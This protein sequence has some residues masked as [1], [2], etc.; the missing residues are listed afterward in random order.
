M[1]RQ[2]FFKQVSYDP[3]LWS[4]NFVQ[5]HWTPF[6]LRHTVAEVLEVHVSKWHKCGSK[7]RPT[8]ENIWSGHLTSTLLPRN[9]VWGHYTLF[10]QR[11]FVD[12]VLEVHVSKLN[13]QTLLQRNYTC[14]K[15]N[16][17]IIIRRHQ[18][19]TSTLVIHVY[20]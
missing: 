19:G 20:E 7:I 4:R 12:K 1:V 11:H 5:G 17:L 15:V 2:G 3:D 13:V 16:I 10:I 18:N 8:W 9:L 6:S 14:G